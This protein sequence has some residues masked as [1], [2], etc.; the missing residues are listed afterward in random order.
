MARSSTNWVPNPSFE[1]NTDGWALLSGSM[2]RVND[3]AFSGSWALELTA[4]EST[5]I[6]CRMQD[7]IPVVEGQGV[8]AAVRALG[9]QEGTIAKM[10]IDFFTDAEVLITGL[11]NEFEIDVTTNEFEWTT[12]SFFMEAPATAASAYV[13]CDFSTD[14]EDATGHKYLLDAV[15][16]RIDEPLDGYFDG[17]STDCE[18]VGTTHDS[19][20]LR[21][22]TQFI[23]SQSH[24]NDDIEILYR[25]YS[26][27]DD[28]NIREELTDWMDGG[29]IKSSVDDDIKRTA[30][31]NFKNLS[32]VVPFVTRLKLYVEIYTEGVL[33]SNTPMGVFSIDMPDGDITYENRYGTI[34]AN[35]ISIELVDSARGKQFVFAKN[36]NIVRSAEDRIVSGRGMKA[37]FPADPKRFGHTEKFPQ[38]MGDLELVNTLLEM[39]NMQG[40]CGD[41]NGIITTQKIRQLS[42]MQPVSYIRQHDVMSLSETNNTDQLCNVVKVYK[43]N[44]DKTP[45]FA[46]VSNNDPTD[47]VS[48]VNMRF[49]TLVIND[50]EVEDSGDAYVLAR[51]KL[52]EGKSFDKTLTLE[53]SPQ[54]WIGIGNVIDLTFDMADGTCYCGRYWVRSWELPLGDPFWMKMEINRI[55][56]FH[57]G[58]PES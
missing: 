44:P 36:L 48:I 49:K 33:T 12:V 46:I 28:L 55:Q 43:D 51:A 1:V 10:T 39:A 24:E 15:E 5:G 4:S 30:S 32:A 7:T 56:K 57:D 3:I 26:V 21:H 29:A 54:P 58:I 37:S 17:D 41:G 50:S 53:V 31:I 6:F 13:A 19:A 45:I 40:C 35:D 20:S 38:W 16:F 18:W 14:S 22:A 8:Y 34:E 11:S 25:L 52:E 27:D 47:P 23:F 42:Q 2:S 9:R